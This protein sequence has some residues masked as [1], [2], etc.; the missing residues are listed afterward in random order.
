MVQKHRG[1]YPSRWA[2]VEPIAPKFGGVPQALLGWV[3]RQAV[4]TGGHGGVTTVEA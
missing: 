3:Q 1:E 4:D 2:A